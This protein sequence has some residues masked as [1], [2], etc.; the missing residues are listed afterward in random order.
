LAGNPIKFKDS[1]ASFHHGPPKHGEHTEEVLA[2]FGLLKK[3]E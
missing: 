1:P 3:E 2:E